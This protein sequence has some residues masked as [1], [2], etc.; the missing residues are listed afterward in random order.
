MRT[1][2]FYFYIRCVYTVQRQAGKS[3]NFALAQKQGGPTDGLPSKP[4]FTLFTGGLLFK[5]K[6]L[7]QVNV[8]FILVTTVILFKRFY[9]S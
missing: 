2:I 7:S 6:T 3:V 4:S 1:K 9:L 5:K 8:S